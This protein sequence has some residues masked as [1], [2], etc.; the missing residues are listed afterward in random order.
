VAAWPVSAA[1]R[2]G[3][4]SGW[5][6]GDGYIC[7]ISIAYYA[8][9]ELRSHY[10]PIRHPNSDNF[11]REQV[12][13]WV[14]HLFASV[15]RLAFHNLVYDTGWLSS[16]FNIAMPLTDR[17]DD[18]SAMATMVDENKFGDK[19]YSLGSLCEWRGIPGKDETLLKEAIKA[20]LGIKT[21][22][23]K[24]PPA[25][26]I[27]QLSADMVGPYAEA[28]ARA[29]LLL[30]ESLNPCLDA[31]GTRK[32]YQLEIDLLPMVQKM[33]LRG[34]KV[35]LDAAER[36]QKLLL[37]KRDAVL[38][39]LGEKLELDCHVGMDELNKNAWLAANCDKFKIE[40]PR[41]EKT[42]APSFTAGNVGWMPKHP[43]WFPRL[44]VQAKKYD[45]A[46]VKFVGNYV[47]D[48]AVKGRIHSE[49]HPHRSEENGTK[50]SRFSYSNPPLQQMPS[51]D[52]EL[53]PLVR[54]IFV[55]EKDEL[56]ATCDQSQ[57]EFRLAVHFAD[58]LNLPGVS[59][60]AELYR[61]N[62]DVDFH[63]IT[64]KRI[65]FDRTTAKQIN[66]AIIYGMGPRK[67][68]ETTGKTEAE[69]KA[70]LDSYHRDMPFL[71]K[72]SEHYTGLAEEQGWIDLID[73]ARRHFDTW[74]VRGIEWN[75]K[76]GTAP[77]SFDE[78]RRRLHDPEHP[79]YGLRVTRANIHTVLNG[80][81]QGS[82]ARQT[83]LWMR[84]CWREGIIPLIQMHDGLEL[85]VSSP[86]Q[87]ERVAK[88]GCEAIGLRIPMRV[89]I[90]YGR[91]WG[92]ATHASWAEALE[93][94]E[95]PEASVRASV[96]GHNGSGQADPAGP[97]P[98]TP[99]LDEEFLA[100]LAQTTAE[101]G[102]ASLSELSAADG[103]EASLSESLVAD[104]G[105][106]TSES[107]AASSTSE[108]PTYILDDDSP[109]L[110]PTS[111][112]G[113]S[114][115]EAKG[116]GGNP[117][118]SQDEGGKAGNG[119]QGLPLYPPPPGG[120]G[121]EDDEKESGD[122]GKG[123][124]DEDEQD[125]P[126][127]DS[128]LLRNGLYDFTAA[129]PYTL[130]D[131]TL[132]YE[133]RRYD[134]KPGVPVT[135]FRRE[136]VFRTRR[137]KNGQWIMNAGKRRVIYNWPAIMKAGPG[138]NV[139]I[140]EG[141]GKV[142]VLTK[143]GLL[144]TTVLSHKWNSEAIA[145]MIDQHVIVL[146]DH[147]EKGTQYAEASRAALMAVAASIRVVP[148]V[149]LWQHLPVEKRGEKPRAGEDIKNW[150][151]DRGGDPAKL[152]WICHKIPAEGE[153]WHRAPIHEWIGKTPPE[154]EYTVENRYPVEETGLLS[155]E[156][157]GGKSTLLE[158]LCSSHVL[159]FVLGKSFDWIGI[160]VRPGPAI[161]V[162][163]EDALNVL[164]RR[165]AMIANHYGVGL[166][167]LVKHLHMFSLREQD[168]TILAFTNKR[169]IVE[170]TPAYNRLREM[171][172]DLKP[173]QIAI[174]SVTNV[175]SG[176]EINRTEVQQFVRL[177][178]KLATLTGGSV[179][180]ATHPSL[181]GLNDKN[182]SH[183]G[184]SGTTQWHN[185]VRARAAMTI[186]KPEGDELGLMDSGLRALTF[187][188]NQYGP[189]VGG[190]TLQ[191]R[192]GLWL[193]I[194]GTTATGAER[195]AAVEN[196]TIV[197]L[198]RFTAQNRL[199][200]IKVNP[201]NY[202]PSEMADTTEAKAAGFTGKD[203]KSAINRLLNREI[204]ENV[205]DPSSDGK[206]ARYHL[207]VKHKETAH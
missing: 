187:Y 12:A 86:E 172:G 156:G 152:L 76:R 10:I 30:R 180:M 85:S 149:H 179:I 9:N 137:Q 130:P 181:T 78:A 38:A 61:T 129:F 73:G 8:G 80:L 5:A 37:Q 33:R 63:E 203:F 106:T 168:S 195:A 51:R 167:P 41:T 36:N 82:A 196:M 91:S 3:R 77:C 26:F 40:Y 123:D 171:A 169:G 71:R 157:Q 97:D 25:S 182:I 104:A 164:W 126:W 145:A 17:L 62:P 4:G 144:A 66:F 18:T 24:Y 23:K 39:M 124:D 105:A 43:H 50:S 74:N 173:V 153:A 14:R 147:D 2:R 69:A 142:D 175:F 194:T 48:Y 57:Q 165:L 114:H 100:F 35:D 45:N 155:S 56:W 185:A 83:K 109:P 20:C 34:V 52:P 143:A 67:F 183:A 135:K 131:E 204:L 46:A 88:L 188:K 21:T 170:P 94:P 29:T 72:L 64:A 198:T 110:V 148:Y 111:D 200:S 68:A 42:G 79:W 191:W 190:V 138:H 15:P 118:S 117:W 174:A 65:G 177:M 93:C 119:P 207:R 134:L 89:D 116:N 55:P 54:G 136:K 1:V 99:V 197:L 7:G 81:I 199:L 120:S 186:I 162:E 75:Q 84:F 113:T 16:E 154:Q 150:I 96:T 6:V 47:L 19:P 141:E 95:G 122:Q 22:K 90:A 60:V 140:P 32:A 163:C 176:S 59:E 189:P 49:I 13:A 202:A 87:A 205:L 44:V 161:Y 133:H 151:K 112:G 70:I 146:A 31:E 53:T 107:P 166:E 184:L 158:Q 201:S 92:S 160:P 101:G 132:L 206:R 108:L 159:S 115:K 103:G 11:D 192:N 28:D 58:S 128:D 127:D 125:V 178:T 121:S 98:E 139:F 27:W 102:E 193:P